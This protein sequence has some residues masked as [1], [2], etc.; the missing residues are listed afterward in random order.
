[1]ILLL[2]ISI[3]LKL[4]L[5]CLLI[6][7]IIYLKNNKDLKFHFSNFHILKQLKEKLNK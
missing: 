6:D 5:I 7:L 4:I 2:I 1:M 3:I